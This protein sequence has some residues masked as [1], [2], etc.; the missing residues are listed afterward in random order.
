MQTP[1]EIND[2]TGVS[3]LP[4]WSNSDA[5]AILSQVCEKHSIPIDV[6]TELVALQR[7]RQHQE[8]A[9]GIFM[10]FEEILGRID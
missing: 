7:E 3:D 9:A 8:R 5:Y 4:L 1:D 2:E 10:R 6:L